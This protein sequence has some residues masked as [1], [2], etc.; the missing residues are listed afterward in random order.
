MVAD[1]DEIIHINLS[2]DTMVDDERIVDNI[3]SFD[4]ENAQHIF[5]LRSKLFLGD[6]TDHRKHHDKVYIC[7]TEVLDV[8]IFQN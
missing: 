6:K 3:I 5:Q 8:T 4:N 1:P 2:E 7:S